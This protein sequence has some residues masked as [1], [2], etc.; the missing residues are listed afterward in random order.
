M[1]ILLW[2]LAFVGVAAIYGGDKLIKKI[3]KSEET[4]KTEFLVKLVGVL[5]SAAA[6]IGLYVTGSFK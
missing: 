2:V 1:K 5:I 4:S 3:C 6:L